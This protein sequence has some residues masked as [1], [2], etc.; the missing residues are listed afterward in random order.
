MILASIYSFILNRP[1]S[2]HDLYFIS[3]LFISEHKFACFFISDFAN[4]VPSINDTNPSEC[5]HSLRYG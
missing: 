3:K 1:Y 5:I 4:A 2:Y